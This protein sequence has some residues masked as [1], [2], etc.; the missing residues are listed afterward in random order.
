MESLIRDGIVYHFEQKRLFTCEQHGFCNGKSCLSNLLETLEDWTQAL[1]EGGGIDAIFLDY[2]KAF[3][4]VPIKRLLCKLNGYGVRGKVNKWIEEFLSNRRMRVCV[5]GEKSEW[6]NV[7]SGVP[8]G[9]VLGPTLF[10]IF[11]NDIP[12]AV[13]CM[14]KMFADD[15]KLYQRIDSDNDGDILQQD[16]DSEIMDDWSEKWLL[17]FNVEKCKRMHLGNNNARRQYE[18]GQG[19]DRRRLEE[20]SEEKDLGVF[21]TNDLKR[22]KQCKE[23]ARKAMNV[24][25]QV[26]STFKV[27]EKEA[28]HIIYKTY[29]RAHLEYAV[30]A[31]S[32][33]YSKDIK[34]LEDVQRRATK[35]VVGLR[36]MD[37]EKRLKKLNLY[38]LE[39]RRLRGD[40]IETFEILSGKTKVYYRKF[41]TLSRDGIRRG[42]KY[43]LEMKRCRT[44]RRMEFFSQRVIY[45]WNSLPG[46]V[47]NVQSV[48]S[49][50]RRLDKNWAR[51]WATHRQH[52]LV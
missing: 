23:S 28:F 9:S 6:T 34:V 4:T 3:D 20:I 52:L 16:I 50:K 45:V 17:K 1:D 14:I 36:N 10:L 24:L 19:V 15:T 37:Y 43:K 30:P 29:I 18:M 41:F 12:E 22:G 48:E 49:F 27:L 35:M 21:L 13:Q 38:S 31:W 11:V 40:L 39:E 32:P 2:R 51:I 47:V 44:L 25:R 5:R 7:T 26:K 33:Y 46:E 8:Q 42:H